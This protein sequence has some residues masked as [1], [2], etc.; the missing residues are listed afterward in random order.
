[1]PA[2]LAMDHMAPVSG[3]F[4]FHGPGTFALSAPN[5]SSL[6]KQADDMIEKINLFLHIMFLKTKIWHL[7]LCFLDRNQQHYQENEKQP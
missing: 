7:I 4:L 3:K 2:A 6:C 1:M 5:S